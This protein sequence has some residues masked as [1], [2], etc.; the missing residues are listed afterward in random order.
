[1]VESRVR[2]GFLHRVHRGVYSVGHR[3]ITNEAHWLAAVLACGDEAVLSHRSA[4]ALWGVRAVATPR[5]D[6]TSS[7]RRGYRFRGIALHR[8]TSLAGMDKTERRGIPVTSLRRTIIDLA[9]CVSPS[10]LEYA[11]HRAEAQRKLVP[12]ELSEILSRLPGTGGT[13]AVRRVIDAAG[14]DIDARTRSPW[15]RRFLSIC[16]GAEIPEPRVNEWI[17]LDVPAGGLEVDFSWPRQRL[18][19]EVDDDASHNTMRARDNDLQRDRALRAAGWA[20][21]RISEAEFGNPDRIA[22]TVL[23][24][25]GGARR[26]IRS[27]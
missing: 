18:V 2:R 23:R 22:A 15:E 13:A 16:R 10:S 19:V 25:L 17:A 24:A 8:A 12:E 3:P 6:V 7:R 27:R 9:T 26:A 14:H 1:M 5:I 11:I 21:T 4:A 20:V